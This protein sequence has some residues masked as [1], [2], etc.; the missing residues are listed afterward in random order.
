MFAAV[1]RELYAPPTPVTR[2][3]AT[4]LALINAAFFGTGNIASVAS[5][6]IL[7]GVP[8]HRAVQPVPHGRAADA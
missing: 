2:H 1:P 8:V 7:L 4:F 6:E 5:F 3:A